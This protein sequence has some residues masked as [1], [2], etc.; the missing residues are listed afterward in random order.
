M[1]GSYEIET[2]DPSFS[3]CE[4]CGGM[5][6][7]LTRFVYRDGDA[8][9]VYYASYSNNHPE[10][11][12]ALLIS[13][14]E[15]GEGSCAEERAAF[16]CGVRQTD[17]S[18]E[19]ML[20]DAASSQ[21]ADVAIMGQKLSRQQALEHPWKAEAFA[22][23]DEAF[24]S[25][26]SLKGFLSRVRCGDTSVPLEYNFM[27]PDE[28]FALGET[29][30]ARAELHRNF[31][32]LD[33]QRFFV[34]CLL[35][36]PV[37]GYGIWC[38]GLWVEVA[39]TDYDQVWRSWDIPEDWARLRLSGRIANDGSSALGLPITLGV[40]LTLHTPDPDAPP[41][42]INSSSPELTTM[43]AETWARNSFEEFA[44]Q[45]GFL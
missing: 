40:E 18:Y 23:L 25:D 6:V 24:L 28:V 8:I 26:R 1:A 14:G 37:E 41:K 39:K 5:S 2:S 4:C 45:R 30:G 42:V 34:R 27:M 3:H 31:A 22:V 15:W 35:P 16:Y 38:V 33:G 20:R 10:D 21:W 12:V 17:D 29:R 32:S 19:V 36:I 9:A 13:L 44:V 7:S 11:E 43:L